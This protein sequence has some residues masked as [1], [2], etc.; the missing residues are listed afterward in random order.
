MTDQA[1]LRDAAAG[2]RAAR[3]ASRL[4]QFPAGERRT[5]AHGDFTADQVLCRGTEVRLIDFDR[6]GLGEPERDLGAFAAGELL[7]GRSLHV[8]LRAGYDRRVDERAVARWTAAAALQRA[9]EPF[10][11]ARPDWRDALHAAIDVAEE[12]IA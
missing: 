1:V 5:L 9:V 11:C 12:A 3:L 2:A 6:A 4:R 8:S 10:R 7:A